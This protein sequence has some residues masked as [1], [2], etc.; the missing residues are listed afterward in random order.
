MV[1]TATASDRKVVWSRDWPVIVAWPVIGLLTLVLTAT[2]V[3][4]AGRPVPWERLA[5][6]I[7]PW[8]LWVLLVPVMMW[9]TRRWSVGV[10][11]PARLIAAHG[12]GFLSMF[13]I[14]SLML[15]GWRWMSHGP[16]VI[17]PGATLREDLS[18][19]IP[20][21][22]LYDV[23][24]YITT[25]AATSTL[26]LHRQLR[27]RATHQAELEQR[28]AEA[29][30]DLMRL[31]V[32][33]SFILR[34]L[35]SARELLG[36]DP[37]RTERIIARLSDV[38]RASLE[39]L[40]SDRTRLSDEVALIRNLVALETLRTGRRVDLLIDVDT[41][42]GNEEIPPLVVGEMVATM[43]HDSPGDVPVTI[44]LNA[45]TTGGLF[46]LNVQIS[47]DSCT[48]T[49]APVTR[50]INERLRAGLLEGW[51][52]QIHDEGEGIVTLSL[53]RETIPYRDE[54]EVMRHGPQPGASAR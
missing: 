13:V 23:L 17:P 38:L 44:E 32:Q 37:R 50:A 28:V 53:D 46:A 41:E 1:S 19:R 18:I 39:M 9:I 20:T 15:Y 45:A 35:R 27:V 16:L 6:N 10:S 7:V 48:T 36:D 33:P 40:E 2:A 51:S 42:S 43:L 29:E 8:T 22:L 3:M 11:T 26:D 12:S 25:M 24:V 30:L 14:H 5:S 47:S 31:Q 52:G 54:R 4:L 34:A 49:L 21:W